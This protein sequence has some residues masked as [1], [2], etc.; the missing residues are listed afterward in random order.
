M[1]KIAAILSFLLLTSFGHHLHSQEIYCTVQVQTPGIQG[2]DPTI[3]E[4]FKTAVTEFMNNRKWTGY[5]FKINER[6]NAT[7]VF[8]FSNVDNDNFTG[9]LNIVSQRPVYNTDYQTTTLNLVDKDI[10]FQYTPTQRMDFTENSYTNNLTSILAYYAYII[11]GIDFDTFSKDGGTAFY[12]KANNI[13][14]SAQNSGETGWSSFDGEKNRYHLVSDLLNSSY[15]DLRVF[16]YNYHRLGLDVMWK[17]ALKGRGEITNSLTLLKKVY[18]K[19]PGLYFLQVIIETKRDELINIFKEGDP[20][21]KNKF[22][23]IMKELDPANGDKYNKV[24]K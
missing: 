23:S 8:T 9:T 16:Y 22:V 15:N 12:Q 11:I 6:I 4:S 5:N 2:V 10:H 19:R 20:A 24:L 1:K 21:E 18:D 7:L 14:N 13:V 17:D 3:F